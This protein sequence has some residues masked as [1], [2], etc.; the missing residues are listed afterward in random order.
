MK[1]LLFPRN[2]RLALFAAALLGAS[3]ATTPHVLTT[4]ERDSHTKAIDDWFA[5]WQKAWLDRDASVAAELFA[6]DAD[7]VYIG[8]DEGEVLV[9]QQAFVASLTGAFGA[10]E[11]VNGFE[12]GDRKV[13]F[14]RD[15]TVAWTTGKLDVDM[16]I[17]GQPLSVK[18]MRGT[19]V[20]ELRDGRWLCV[21]SHSSMGVPTAAPAQ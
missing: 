4:A 3:C 15:G 13:F 2:T 16:V 8:T 14:S 21:Q 5:R 7:A 19:S 10:I 12:L 1:E 9:G 17:G 18:G 20:L 6:P 11:K